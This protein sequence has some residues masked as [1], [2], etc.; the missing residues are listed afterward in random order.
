MFFERLKHGLDSVKPKNLG[1]VAVWG[2]GDGVPVCFAA[3]GVTLWP[4]RKGQ[5]DDRV[6]HGP[7]SV[8]AVKRPDDDAEGAPGRK[9]LRPSCRSSALLTARDLTGLNWNGFF[10]CCGVDRPFASIRYI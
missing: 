9:S 10:F 6:T 8:R 3:N 7:T 2:E 1:D 4:Q 5:L